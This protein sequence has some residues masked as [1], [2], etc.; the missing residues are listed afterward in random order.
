MIRL[1]LAVLIAAPQEDAGARAKALVLE[2]QGEDL[3]RA[4]RAA[5]RL[6][7]LGEGA[8][9]AI[10]A[11]AK[12]APEPKRARLA[13]AADEVRSAR[14]LKAAYPA[15]KRFSATASGKTSLELLSDLR[16]A[17]G[18]DLELSDLR[19]EENLPKVAVDFKDATPFEAMTEI[20]RAAGAS[21]YFEEGA[22]TVYTGGFEDVPRFFFG[23]FMVT[24]ESHARVRTVKFGEPA[25]ERLV[26]SLHAAWN[27]ALPAAGGRPP[28]LLEARDEKGGSLIPP[29]PG[30]EDGEP[31]GE[32]P[33]FGASSDGV[34]EDLELLPLPAGTQK[35]ALL[36]A[37]LPLS[38]P[39]S[40][41]VAT[42]EKPK[43]GARQESEGLSATVV[44]VESKAGG[45]F[46]AQLDLSVA[47]MKPEELVRK[48]MIL[49]LATAGGRRLRATAQAVEEEGKA[50]LT[51]DFRESGR[52]LRLAAAKGAAPPVEG[53]RVIVVQA[54]Y[55]RRIPFE[56][57]DLKIK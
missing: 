37:E 13:L 49:E 42:F 4:Y 45:S 32:E 3:R 44:A 16:Q 8:L 30:K 39:K 51:C 14:D 20:C 12:A 36:R 56:F 43:A 34:Y 15:F 28:R 29:S 19:D 54:L 40:A 31:A 21:W 7:E 23:H 53:L 17:T 6:A 46:R 5:E 11:A 27:P 24:L 9:T 57:R 25:R 18:L 35:V 10:E 55:E 47:G 22:I 1:A 41:L 26:L 33:V 2:A 50:R 48:R 38:L 52:G